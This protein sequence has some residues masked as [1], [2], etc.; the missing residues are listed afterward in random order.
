MLFPPSRCGPC[1]PEPKK[2]AVLLALVALAQWMRHGHRSACFEH[3]FEIPA[4]DIKATFAGAGAAASAASDH[5][6]QSG[7]LR[8]RTP[9]SIGQWAIIGDT[10]LQR[11]PGRHRRVVPKPQVLRNHTTFESNGQRVFLTRGSSRPAYKWRLFF[12]P[13]IS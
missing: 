4:I 13:L 7:F 3:H 9:R 10:R 2:R 5:F 11:C 1:R 12:G 6:G 8:P